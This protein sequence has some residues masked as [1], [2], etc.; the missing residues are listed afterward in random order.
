MD[1]IYKISTAL[2]LAEEYYEYDSPE[3]HAFYKGF[4]ISQ[5]Y[6]L[7]KHY[8]CKC[9]KPFREPGFDYCEICHSHV[10]PDRMDEIIAKE[11][12]SEAD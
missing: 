4:G 8:N 3:W 12:G 7:N 5:S 10:H 9:E 11:N 6:W 2:D 1:E